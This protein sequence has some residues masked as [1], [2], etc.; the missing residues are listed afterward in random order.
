MNSLMKWCKTILAFTA[1]VKS[2][3]AF[4]S[5][6]LCAIIACNHLL[7]FKISSNFVHFC[8]NFQIFCPFFA[9]FNIF[10]LFC[11]FSEKS[12]ALFEKIGPVYTLLSFWKLLY[13]KSSRFFLRKWFFIFLDLKISSKTTQS[14]SSSSVIKSMTFYFFPFLTHLNQI[15]VFQCLSLSLLIL[16]L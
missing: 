13:L 16:L 8:S 7:F 1:K 2:A 15:L 6:L 11:S 4:F 14:T 9:I 3:R 5:S 10:P 12:P